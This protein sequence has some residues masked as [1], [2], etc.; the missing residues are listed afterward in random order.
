MSY[1]VALVFESIRLFLCKQ[2]KCEVF[3][4]LYFLYFYSFNRGMVGCGRLE[5][6]RE[7]VLGAFQ[8]LKT[9]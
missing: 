9:L 4:F 7:G 3:Y 1:N 6:I 2:R 5:T 8:R